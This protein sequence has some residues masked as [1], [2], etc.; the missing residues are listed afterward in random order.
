MLQS[1]TMTTFKTFIITLPE[2]T[3]R[4]DHM[5]AQ[6]AAQDIEDFDFF[7]A[8]DGR[9]FDVPTHENYNKTKRRIFFGRDL[10][11]GELG[12][13]LSHKNIYQKMVTEHIDLAL[14]FEDDAYMKD[15]FKAVLD[16]LK[17][18]PKDFDL[19]RFLG[20]KKVSKLEQ[21]TKRTVIGKYT[22]NALRTSPGGAFAYLITLDG[23]KKML[24]LLDRFFVPIDTLMGHNWCN[25]L[26]AYIIQPG[27]SEQ[28]TS[29]E[30]YI[31]TERFEKRLDLP[32]PMRLF[33]PLT[34]AAYKAYEGI[35]KQIWYKT[36]KR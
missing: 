13:T 8:V 35:M 31:G 32:M 16:A 11:G 2:A 6:M 25:K 17:D 7:P 29:Q 15:D 33:F 9:A 14:I 26:D 28:D 1:I 3:A 34:R 23:A 19:I 36:R 27:L 21:F 4:Q 5:R 22:L 12:V 24:T 20:S 10:K 30:Q 18:G